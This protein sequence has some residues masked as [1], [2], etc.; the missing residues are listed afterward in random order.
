MY[1]IIRA[2]AI[3]TMK[4]VK[5]TRKPIPLPADS[6]RAVIGPMNP[7]IPNPAEKGV[8]DILSTLET[9]PATADAIMTGINNFG[10]DN[11]LAI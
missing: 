9:P 5:L 10:F 6:F 11:I 3:G 8:P 1:F 2:I 7:D 4:K